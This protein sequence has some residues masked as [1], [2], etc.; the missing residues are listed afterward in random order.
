MAYYLIDSARCR[1]LHEP[2]FVHWRGELSF[3]LRMHAR[4]RTEKGTRLSLSADKTYALIRCG[5]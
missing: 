2:A 3:L 4:R 1:V 5:T